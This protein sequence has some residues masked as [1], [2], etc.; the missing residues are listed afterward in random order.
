MA[1]LWA[2][3]SR[4]SLLHAVTEP[5][6]TS[7]TTGKENSLHP[8]QLEPERLSQEGIARR[9][10]VVGRRDRK[11]RAILCSSLRSLSSPDKTSG[12]V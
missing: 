8:L 5:G 12:R 1:P 2:G 6:D 11:S 9:S 3:S 10:R 4:V 7:L